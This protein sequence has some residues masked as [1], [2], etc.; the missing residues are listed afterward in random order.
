MVDDRLLVRNR[1]LLRWVTR[2]CE[3]RSIT[4]DCV[5]WRPLLG[6]VSFWC[7]KNNI[8]KSKHLSCSLKLISIVTPDD[9]AC[10]KEKILALVIQSVD[11]VYKDVGFYSFF[12]RIS[13]G[14]K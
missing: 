14:K 2:V 5:P 10:T 3:G 4:R 1:R 11:C 12:P 9:P 7:W 6:R 8:E 13:H